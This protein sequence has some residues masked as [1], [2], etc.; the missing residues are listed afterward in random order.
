VALRLLQCSQQAVLIQKAIVVWSVALC[1]A[2]LVWLVWQGY[3]FQ[4]L[5]SLL[6][7]V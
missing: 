3:Q 2:Y 5:L 6:G 7:Q 1:V 4:L